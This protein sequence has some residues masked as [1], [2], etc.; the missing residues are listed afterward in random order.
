MPIKPAVAF[1]LIVVGTTSIAQTGT[2]VDRPPKLEEGSTW[3]YRVIDMY[4]KTNASLR[5]VRVLKTFSDGYELE[6]IGPTKTSIQRA[7]SDLN[8]QQTVDGN[9]FSSGDY[10]WPLTL[11]KKWETVTW[12]KAQDGTVNKLQHSREVIAVETITVP[13]GEFETYK[14]QA[15]G[16][17]S[18]TSNPGNWNDIYGKSQYIYWYSPKVRQVVAYESRAWARGHNPPWWKMELVTYKN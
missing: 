15:S 2:L 16:T 5:S 9:T 4:T 13:A 7:D 14:V 17:W 18:I 8:I 11:G 10:S 3:N 6:Y 1:L 12:Y